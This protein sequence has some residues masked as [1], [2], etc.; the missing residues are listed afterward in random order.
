MII[1][2]A[3]SGIK[4]KFTWTISAHKN[5]AFLSTPLE[6][7]CGKLHDSFSISTASPFHV[8]HYHTS[9]SKICLLFFSFVQ[10]YCMMQAVIVSMCKPLA[11][12][13]RLNANVP[14]DKHT[15]TP[16]FFQILILGTENR[17]M[18]SGWSSTSDHG[19]M[20]ALHW[21]T[22]GQ[23]STVSGASAVLISTVN[24]FKLYYSRLLE[25]AHTLCCSSVRSPLLSHCQ[26]G[27]PGA[28]LCVC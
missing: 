6:A 11:P 10:N 7:H 9:F 21:K 26:T 17:S 2:A 14:G 23:S 24:L 19:I 28:N 8:R 16:L 22:R 12:A 5:A 18:L 25:G 3:R 13:W 15:M 27:C 20:K 1:S 4:C